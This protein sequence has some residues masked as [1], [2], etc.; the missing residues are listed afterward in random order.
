M[1]R[2]TIYTQSFLLAIDEQ[3][4]YHYQTT[5]GDFSFFAFNANIGFVR[6]KFEFGLG[7]YFTNGD[8]SN[9]EREGSIIIPY[10]K[11]SYQLK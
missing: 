7:A 8:A 2:G 1:N 4:F 9:F 6:E 10:F 3:G 5:Q 11:I